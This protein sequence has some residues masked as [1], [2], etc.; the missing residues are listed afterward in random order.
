MKKRSIKLSL[1]SILLAGNVLFAQEQKDEKVEQLEEVVLS[2]TKFELKK[3]HS[4]KIIYKITKKDI[5]QNAGKTVIELLDKVAGVEINGSN[6]SKGTNLGLYFRGGRSRQ[7]AVM[8]DG[9]LVSDPTGIVA[10]YNLNLIDV[11]QIES[12]EIL[13][14]SS[15][16]L[17]GSG[18][19]TGVINIILKKASKKPFSLD[20]LA[21]LGTNETQH[22]R[23]GNFD[24]IN[25]NIG[26]RGTLNKF[27]YIAN[28][29]FTSS[30]GMSAA[31]D[32][33]SVTPFE[34]DGF[35]SENALM[36]LGYE[37]NDKLSFQ[38]FGNYN[39]YDYDYDAGLYED[40]DINNGFYK[41][42]KHGLKVN[43]S[44]KNGELIVLGSASNLKRGFNSYSSWTSTINSYRYEGKSLF[45]ELVNKYTIN[46]EFHFIVGLNYQDFDNQTNSPYGTIDSNIAKYSTIDPYASVVYN[47][48]NGLNLNVG[49][50]LNNHSEYGNHFVYHVNPSYNVIAS[51]QAKVKVLASYSTAYITPSTYQLFSQY[52]NLDLKPEE[53]TTIE[54]GF[55]ASYKKWLTVSSVF[56]YR[57]ETNKVIFN[58]DPITF[59]SQY[60]N[61][62]DTTNAKGVETTVKLKPTEKIVVNLA[63]TYT[64]KSQDF[65]YIPKN[66]ISAQVVANLFKTTTVSLGFKNVSNRNASYYD[67]TTFSTVDTTMKSYNLVDFSASFK[68]LDK[69]T[70]FG[71]LDNALNEDYEDIYG[72]STRGRNVKLGVKLNF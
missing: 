62:D 34:T 33:N 42:L 64:Y 21:S 43:Y 49:A 55:D 19:A 36:K 56:F 14:G 68:P 63:H 54:F 3:E 72:Y 13:K 7:V 10:T 47:G 31:S 60:G 18:A 25:Q 12:I 59:V 16:T 70:I 4:G 24:E 48:K 69:L 66:K 29:G 26:V 17:Y 41:E 65:N 22:N 53:N 1:L 67:S 28:V 46:E 52:G 23:K 15:S 40:S 30:N 35:N 71:V 58:F 11:N 27:N 2:D 5:E 45:A 20:Y 32:I 61:A 9:V 38:F 57:D 37:A 39:Q 44:Y 6:N 50:R 8:I 51:S